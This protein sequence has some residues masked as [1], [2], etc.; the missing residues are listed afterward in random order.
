MFVEETLLLTFSNNQV[1]RD[2]ECMTDDQ[3]LL[4]EPIVI[5]PFDYSADDSID[6]LM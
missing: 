2:Q 1:Y 5:S 6:A 3:K 4:P